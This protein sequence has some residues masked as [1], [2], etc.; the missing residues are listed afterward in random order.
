MEKDLKIF[1]SKTLADGS[2]YFSLFEKHIPA[3]N[4]GSSVYLYMLGNL[5]C[6]C[7][8]IK[9][10]PTSKYFICDTDEVINAVQIVMDNIDIS[11]TVDLYD[12][13]MNFDCII[14]NPPYAKNLHLK[15]LAEA[16][17]HLKDDESKVINLSPVRWLQDPLAKYKKNSD[18]N[19][20]EES[21]S[22][23]LHDIDIYF[24]N[25]M[26]NMFNIQI[27]TDLAIYVAT[28]ENANIKIDFTK[29]DNAS[30]K[31]IGF[32]QSVY[33][34]IL[35]KNIGNIEKQL[36]VFKN[37]KTKHYTFILTIGGVSQRGP[38]FETHYFVRSGDYGPFIDD[39]FNGKTAK[40]IKALNKRSVWGDVDNW[41]VICFDNAQHNV[42]FFKSSK[43]IFME[44]L[45]WAFSSDQH[46]P[47]WALPWMGDSINPRTGL[48]G[49][50]S[51][52]TDEDFYQFFNITDAEKKIIEETMAKYNKTN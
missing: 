14:M 36:V 16:I 15:I 19:K 6:I 25:N 34:R 44:F 35:A 31:N 3:L 45:A 5:P 39:K 7:E 2:K 27:K 10:N 46:I 28:K 17:K 21:I 48:K 47:N 11:K 33:D 52:W 38:E 4:D 18:Y 23:K 41:P 20:F 12:I 24:A 29:L 9:K 8:I 49:Y 26:S 50:E 13:D 42:N 30:S 37:R 51:E 32:V 40:E 22:N 1:K 43:S